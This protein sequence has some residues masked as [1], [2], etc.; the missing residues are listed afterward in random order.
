MSSKNEVN[1]FAIGDFGFP[2]E[3]VRKTAKAMSTWAE[4]S[5]AAFILA[6]GDSK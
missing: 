3:A 6:L 5:P 4:S 1:F 2:T